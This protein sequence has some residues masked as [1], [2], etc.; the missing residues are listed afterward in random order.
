MPSSA[1][2][3]PCLDDLG[4]EPVEIGQLIAELLHGSAHSCGRAVA[5]KLRK[6]TGVPGSVRFGAFVVDAGVRV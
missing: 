2:A 4:A 3:C 6:A 1:S 5:A